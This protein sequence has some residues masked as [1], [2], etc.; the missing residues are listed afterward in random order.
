MRF[1][2]GEG[3]VTSAA[4]SPDGNRIAF[5]L[6]QAIGGSIWVKQSNGAGEP[7]LLLR[8]NGR[9][10]ADSWSAD[11]RVL[12][13]DEQ[14]TSV[15]S[16]IWQLPMQGERKPV[17]VLRSE[18]VVRDARLSPDGRWMA[19]VSNE[20][21]RDE[22][23]MRAMAGA[24]GKWMIS[25]EG[26]SEPRWSRTGTELF[27]LSADGALMSVE[28]RFEGETL[29]AGIP[30]SLFLTRRARECEVSPDGR[31]FLIPVNPKEAENESIYVV[32]NWAED[33]RR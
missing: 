10:A 30:R 33:L 28:V 7:K 29:R 24:G 2:S 3:S 13:Y 18:F 15:Q 9:L 11:G 1:T 22:I 17:P 25:S 27:F 20:T 6:Q 5:G 32:L 8:T 19:Y 4:W 31:R 26:G 12:L 16:G 21:G 14:E 23:Y